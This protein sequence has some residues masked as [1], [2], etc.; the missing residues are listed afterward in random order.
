MCF[1]DLGYEAMA[2]RLGVRL[3]DLNN[4]PTVLLQNPACR[5]FPRFHMP[6]IAMTHYIISVPVLK[7]HSLAI[8][9]GTMKNMMGFAPPAHYQQGGHWKKSAFHARMHESIVDLIRYRAPD[10]SLMDA[11][12][13][14]PR[15]GE[16]SPARRAGMP[17]FHLAGTGG[18]P[19]RAGT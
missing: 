15:R 10:L 16:T 12:I 1:R 3:V 14:P 6:E 8:I 7:A 18:S 5:V 2:K 11:R 9:T 17:E 4:E 19:S 13:G